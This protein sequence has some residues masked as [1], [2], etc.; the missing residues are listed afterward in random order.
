MYLG[1][2][3]ALSVLKHLANMGLHIP[4]KLINRLEGIKH[5]LDSK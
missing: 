5:D 4:I 1:V 3:E 2:T